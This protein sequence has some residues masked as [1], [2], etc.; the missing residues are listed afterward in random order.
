MG[1]ISRSWNLVKICAT[2]MRSEKNLV[3]FPLIS[4][5]ALV[6]VTISFAAPLWVTGFFHH[7]RPH[8]AATYAVLFCFYFVSYF[9]MIFANAALVGAA[10]MALH[11]GAPTLGDGWRIALD[12][13][14]TI[15]GY[16]VISATVGLALRTI[17][18]RAG[19]LGRIVV[20]LLGT[21]WSVATFLAVPALVYE[22]IGPVQAVKRSTSLLKKTWGE[23]IVG[24]LGVGVVFALL[25]GGVVT[26]GVV[27]IVMAVAAKMAVLAIVWAALMVMTLL[28]LGL[29]GSTFHG[30]FAAAVYQYA[31][32]GD[33]GAFFSEAMVRDAFRAK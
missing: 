18:Q 33:T 19:L 10:L 1:R 28:V 27:L 14:G 8:S 2:I 13:A 3:V 15:A 6:V 26:A 23:Q 17:S 21:A 25:G 32:E 20:A 12:H 29:I 22:D 30:I 11:G 4:G 16:A 9:V 7:V 31:V 5:L 24:N